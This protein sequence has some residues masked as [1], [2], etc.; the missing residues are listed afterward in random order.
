MFNIMEKGLPVIA[1]ELR[2][3]LHISS[4]IEVKLFKEKFDAL[5]KSR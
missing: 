3:R 5:A 2:S 1:S 4:G